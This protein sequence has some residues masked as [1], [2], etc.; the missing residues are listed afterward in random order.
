MNVLAKFIPRP[1]AGDPG[2]H[3]IAVIDIG[4]NSIR[5]VVFDG[6]KRAFLPVFNEKVI[7]GLGRGMAKSGRLSEDG[8]A[9]A[10]I[11][12]PRFVGMARGMGVTDINLLATEA[13]REAEN[14]P[15]FI[16]EVE[17]RCRQPVRI[18]SGLEEAHM[19]GLGVLVGA[20]DAEGVM[21]DLG[22][23]SLEL[24]ELHEGALGES[25]TLPMGALRLF[26]LAKDGERGVRR[27]I[28]RYL[29][30]VDWLERLRDRDFYA[31][32]GS[33][34]NLA[35]LHMSQRAYPV[36]VMQGYSLEQDEA[37]ELVQLVGKLDPQALA[38]IPDVPK[39]R[40]EVLPHAALLLGR[41]LR[42]CSPRRVVLSA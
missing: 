20:P 30:S 37:I 17:R 6:L 36:H 24:I 23:G 41:I 8:V 27:E 18:L 21:G 35:R 33:W 1:M 40:L 7:C 28:D 14:G 39:R 10:L 26:D 32:G 2:E 25:T 15:D 31:V 11:N 9:Q 5:L 13:A 19:S 42:H 34:R 38:G 29:D 4:S 12:L 3:R 22:G 16:A